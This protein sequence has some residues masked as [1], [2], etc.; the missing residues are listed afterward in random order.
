MTL[1]NDEG[2]FVNKT[3]VSRSLLKGF[4]FYPI[5]GLLIERKI[6][7]MISEFWSNI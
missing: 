4:H 2:I 6:I 5:F 1:K 3:P 7:R